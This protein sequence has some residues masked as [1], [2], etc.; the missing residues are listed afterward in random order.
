MKKVL[1][2]FLVLICMLSLV[3]CV[4]LDIDG[5]TPCNLEVIELGSLKI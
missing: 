5:P 1:I 2:L 4:K 3:A